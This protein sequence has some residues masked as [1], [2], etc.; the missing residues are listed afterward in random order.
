MIYDMN[1]VKP[2]GWSD[3]GKEYI[4]DETAVKPKGIY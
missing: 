3:D 2:E 1:A 4:E